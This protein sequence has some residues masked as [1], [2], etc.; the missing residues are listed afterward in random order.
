LTLTVMRPISQGIKKYFR[1][2]SRKTVSA[3]PFLQIG[4]GN[5]QG[6][7]IEGGGVK[8]NMFVKRFCFSLCVNIGASL[9]GAQFQPTDLIIL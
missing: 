7:G 3:C 1:H 5:H 4:L 9:R 6:H 8:T 2:L